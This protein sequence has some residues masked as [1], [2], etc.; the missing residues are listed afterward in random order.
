MKKYDFFIDG[1][2]W[3]LS[4]LFFTFVIASFFVG[5]ADGMKTNDCKPERLISYINVPWR[6]SC[7]MSMTR[8]YITGKK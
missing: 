1:V 7:E 3:A 4:L 6:L 8:A 2:A 5:F